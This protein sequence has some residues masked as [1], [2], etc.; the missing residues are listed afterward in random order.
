[1]STSRPG[2]DLR[3]APRPLEKAN[4]FFEGKTSA[5]TL[6]PLTFFPG[7]FRVQARGNAR[8]LP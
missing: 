5:S 3:A 4:A 7:T 8:G 1:M 6:S 2:P